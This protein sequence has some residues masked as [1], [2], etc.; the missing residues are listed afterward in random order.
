MEILKT[1]GNIQFARK[2]EDNLKSEINHDNMSND[3]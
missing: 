2:E 1:Q 3:D